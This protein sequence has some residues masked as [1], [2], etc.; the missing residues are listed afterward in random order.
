[1]IATSGP[2]GIPNGPDTTPP[3]HMGRPTLRRTAIGP[4]L[5]QRDVR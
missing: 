4:T 5:C 3:Q 1:M 2:F